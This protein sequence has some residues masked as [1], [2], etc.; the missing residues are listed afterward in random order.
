[1][2]LIVN[3]RKFITQ[4][5][6]MLAGYFVFAKSS[7][8]RD[9]KV[10]TVNG[11]MAANKM[12]FALSHEHI[13]VD[14]IGANAVVRVFTNH[15]Q[16]TNSVSC[17]HEPGHCKNSFTLSGTTNFCP[18]INTLKRMAPKCFLYCLNKS[19]VYAL[20]CRSNAVVRVFTKHLQNNQFR[21]VQT[22]TGAL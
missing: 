22:R 20:F 9:N 19:A 10:M 5:T 8:Y 15:F 4:S 18:S 2:A 17:R 12:G 7:L 6:C 14:F 16:T 13:L 3:R 21:F 11:W 1:M